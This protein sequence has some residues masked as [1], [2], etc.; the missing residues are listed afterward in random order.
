MS[1]DDS[2]LALIA[3][4]SPTGAVVV[5]PL[6]EQVFDT[7]RGWIIN[8]ELEPGQRLRVRDVATAVGTSVMP[9]REA[10]KRLVDSGLAEH[11][12]YKGARVRSLD[13]AE[14]EH[15]YDVRILLEGECARLGVEASA[16]GIAERMDEHWQAL[17]SAAVAGDVEQALALDEDLL[18]ELYA[19]S[20]NT[21]LVQLIRGLWDQ[22][23][24]YKAA[25]ARAAR[26]DAD[27]VGIWHFKPQLIGAVREGDAAAAQRI[28][29]TSYEEAKVTI[30]LSLEGGNGPDASS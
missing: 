12:P 16:P 18:G 3:P 23:R 4:A 22:C 11:E 10:I 24:P 29:R 26:P 15:T 19:A 13:I 8:G 5:A 28:I 17:Q 7:L 20:G 25:W 9:V 1:T 21:V 27:G 30:R 2:S 6:A 14:L